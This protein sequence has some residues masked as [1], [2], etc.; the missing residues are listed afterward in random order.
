MER[1]RSGWL[2][3]AVTSTLSAVHSPD[4]LVSF[5]ADG[6]IAGVGSVIIFLPNIFLLFLAIAVLEDT[7]YMARA[8][9]IMDR[10]MHRIGLHGKSFIPMLM[11]FGCNVPAIMATITLESRKDRILTILINPLMSCAARLPVYVLI[12][13]AFFGTYAGHAIFSMYLMG[14]ILAVLMGLLFKK[15]FFPGLAAPFVM[16]LPPYRIPTL[17][18]IVIHMWE[19]GSMF[20]KKAGT[21]IFLG[22]I[23]VWLLG[24]LPWGVEYASE[25]SLAG[26]LG[27]FFAPVLKPLGFDWR[28]AVALIFG[29]V[30]K[31]IVVGTFGTLFHVG[32]EGVA[33]ALQ[34]VMTPLSAYAFMAFTLIYIPCLATIGVIKKETGSW[35]W[36]LFAVAYGLVLA[37]VVS[38]IIYQG[39][40]LLG[41]G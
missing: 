26:A 30:A 4:W 35:G 13:G 15:L 33:A 40:R 17:K 3:E 25:A 8:A 2:G 12:A 34:Q 28:A 38:F 22:V 16:E 19:R 20:L 23:A 29:F 1:R 27:R 21:I 9:F 5:L 37:W 31:E 10:I 41:L 14:I 36:T 32:E 7:G 18:G 6:V 24:S 11:G 39:G